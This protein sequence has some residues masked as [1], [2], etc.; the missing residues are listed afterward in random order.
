MNIT[1]TELTDGKLTATVV[2]PS[3][4][5]DAAIRAAYKDI[6]NNYRFQG[7]RRGKAPRPMI[8][9][10]FGKDMVMAQA[11]NDLLGK[12][13]PEVL[14]ELDIVPVKRGELKTEESVVDGQDYTF[15]I[16]YKVRPVAELSS[17]DAV[18]IEMPPS[19]ASDREIEAQ[20]KML[21][22]YHTSFQPVEDGRGVENDDVV[23]AEIESVENGE[24][25]AGKGRM[26]MVGSHNV[27]DELDKGLLGMKVGETKEISWTPEG[28]D[29]APVTVKVTVDSIR[30]RTTPELTDEFVKEAFGFESVDAMRDAVRLEI[31]ADKQQQFPSLKE[32]RA[33]AALAERLELEEMDEDYE[34][35]VF[36]DLGQN[37]LSSLSQSGMSLDTWLQQS[38]LTS[39]QFMNDLHRQAADVARESL[40]LD[41]LARHLEVEV[42]EED[43]DREFAN[44]GV[45]D[46][47][48]TKASFVAD[49]RIPAVRDSIRR[50]KAVD[51]LL[52]NA[53]VTE[54]DDYEKAKE[55]V[56]AIE[57]RESA[58]EKSE[59]SEEE[60]AE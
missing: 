57:A 31:E 27:S 32:N 43:I 22:S 40:A 36:S 44:A 15:E 16:E 14:N 10:M 34:Q 41:A 26:I 46:P 1:N 2:I 45:E 7:F 33:V 4:D 25:L 51:W 56:E 35:S 58:S 12:R 8:D 9:A 30:T 5:V 28:D 49:G 21:M 47:E 17:Y 29:A 13:E 52:E 53:K 59:D 19:K 23:N 11:T 60:V 6:A 54:V 55:R 3:S 50:S 24:S 37:F 48:E 38:H 42:T 18:E 20:V 39:E